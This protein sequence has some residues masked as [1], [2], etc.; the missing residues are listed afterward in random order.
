MGRRKLEDYLKTGRQTT[1]T[2]K[3]IQYLVT[4]GCSQSPVFLQLQRYL[5]KYHSYSLPSPQ[6][7]ISESL[8]QITW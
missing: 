7:T 1:R 5:E 4:P 6:T 2:L 8:L 3:S